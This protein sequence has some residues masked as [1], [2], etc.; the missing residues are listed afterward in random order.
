MLVQPVPPDVADG[1]GLLP[2]FEPAS[3][4]LAYIGMADQELDLLIKAGDLS[5]C[6]RPVE[7]MDVC[8]AEHCRQANRAIEP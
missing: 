7:M 4:A 1:V 6:R 5:G 2:I 3:A 8:H